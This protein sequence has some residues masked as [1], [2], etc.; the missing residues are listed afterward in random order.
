MLFEKHK[1]EY[2]QSLA[3]TNSN[4]NAML[5]ITGANKNTASET[6]P[7]TGSDTR[8]FWIDPAAPDRGPDLFT[9]DLNPPNGAIP[10]GQG[11][12]FPPNAAELDWYVRDDFE[13]PRLYQLVDQRWKMKKIGRKREWVQ[14]NHYEFQ[15]AFMSDRSDTDRARPFEL[16]SIHDVMTERQERSDPTG[17]EL[18]RKKLK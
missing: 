8:L 3:E 16:R 11:N 15:R 5:A 9:D 6:V 17:D 4:L 10:I 12:S 13:P 14:Y 7:T 18:T 2:G 1:N